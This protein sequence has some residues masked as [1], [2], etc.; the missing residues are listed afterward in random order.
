[1]IQLFF[2]LRGRIEYETMHRIHN[3]NY[4]KAN[5]WGSYNLNLLLL[6]YP[7][8]KITSNLKSFSS[9]FIINFHKF[10]G[11]YVL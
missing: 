1:M 9:F 4:L 3:F 6:P 7:Q 11:E 5:I 10:M 8:G 2:K